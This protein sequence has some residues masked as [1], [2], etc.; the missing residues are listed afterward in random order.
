MAGALI[1]DDYEKFCRQVAEH[2]LAIL[3]LSLIHKKRCSLVL[4][5]GNTPA[6]IYR[7]LK[8]HSGDFNW[9]V[10]GFLYR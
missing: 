1:Y 3:K 6:G 7:Y 10:C 9:G 8:D 2:I 4:S 5:G